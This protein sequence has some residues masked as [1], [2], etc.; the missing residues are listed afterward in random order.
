MRR[1]LTCSPASYAGAVGKED[2]AHW[3]RT[4]HGADGIPGHR[5]CG[6]A[7]MP[8]SSSVSGHA[9]GGACRRLCRCRSTSVVAETIG[10]VQDAM[11]AQAP[12]C[13]PDEQ[14][15][16]DHGRHRVPGKPEHRRAGVRQDAERERLRRPDG[17]LHPAHV[18]GAQFLQH[19]PHQVE[20][21]DAHASA[22]Q[23]G[24]AGRRRRGQHLDQCGLIVPH[25]PEVDAVPPFA[26]DEGQQGVAVGVADLAGGSGPVPEKSSSPVEST[27]TRGRGWTS[28]LATP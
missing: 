20:V 13:R 22:G 27:P 18:P 4:W 1:T 9:G 2:Q 10:P 28:T 16:A 5:S 14:L 15:E 21:A 12:Q 23:D 7:T 3:L 6:R 24:I 8:V 26:A 25:D 11:A 19:D 17:H